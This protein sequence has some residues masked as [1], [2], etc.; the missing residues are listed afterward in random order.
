MKFS[1]PIWTDGRRRIKVATITRQIFFD[2]S[3]S[4]RT[5]Y[6][7]LTVRAVVPRPWTTNPITLTDPDIHQYFQMVCVNYFLDLVSCTRNTIYSRIHSFLVQLSCL[8]LVQL[9]K[10]Y[11][12]H[13]G[14][15]REVY[16]GAAA[17][18]L[19]NTSS[20]TITEVKQH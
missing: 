16:Q 12:T 10:C 5:L 19:E 11:E 7:Q 8:W 9:R 1:I 3:A 6:G 14:S 4:S 2:L 13:K 17:Y 18:Q 15:H 20:C